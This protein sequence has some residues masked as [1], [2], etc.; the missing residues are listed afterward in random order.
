MQTIKNKVV[1]IT[2]AGSGIGRA[3]AI[4]MAN[5]GAKLALNSRTLS[6]LEE[7]ASLLNIEKAN[8][9]TR[10]FD[11]SKKEEVFK[12]AEEVKIKFG[13]A[14]ILINN[15]G[16]AITGLTFEEL[17]IEDFEWIFSINFMGVVNATK[18]F[19]PILQAQ[20]GSTTIVN[21]SSVFGLV[22]MA[23]KTPY[24]ATKYAI[25]GLT[26][27]LRME[28]DHTSVNVLGVYPGGVKT[29]ITLNA[30]KAEKEPEYTKAFD[31][32]LVM[33]PEKAAQLI[34]DAIIRRKENLVIGSDAKKAIFAHRFFPFILKNIANKTMKKFKR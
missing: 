4:A 18:A 5:Q 12:F 30:L 6:N 8:L 19:L 13:K 10:T 23:L 3:L 14:D 9:L 29:G 27:S 24:C 25:K 34:V 2:G 33:A 31:Q 20:N 26:D 28:L 7:T 15:A 21:M 17:E 22:P 1:I 32:N 16:V 11:I